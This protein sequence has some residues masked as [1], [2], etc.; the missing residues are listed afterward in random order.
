MLEEI[1]R[2]KEDTEQ[3][4]KQK[5]KQTKKTSASYKR[6][7]W[8][9]I[10]VIQRENEIIKAVIRTQRWRLRIKLQKDNTDKQPTVPE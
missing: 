1:R 7:A 5:N 4:K 2:E 9:K 6:N 10:K 8:E 3:N